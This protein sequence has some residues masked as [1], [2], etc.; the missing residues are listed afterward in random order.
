MFPLC[1]IY[2]IGNEKAQAGARYGR[3]WIRFKVV[4]EYCGLG[5]YAE[6]P[7]AARKGH[8]QVPGSAA[9]FIALS[10]PSPTETTQLWP[11]VSLARMVQLP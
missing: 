1:S 6:T 3:L 11:R 10:Q 8:A 2:G 9:V 5:G 7:A 4:A